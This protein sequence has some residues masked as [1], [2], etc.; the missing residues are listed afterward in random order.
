MMSYRGYRGVKTLSGALFI[1]RLKSAGFFPTVADAIA[2]IDALLFQGCVAPVTIS[3]GPGA[4]NTGKRSGE[5]RQVGETGSAR[6]AAGIVQSGPGCGE[7]ERSTPDGKE[8]MGR[9]YARAG[10]IIL[11]SA[12][13]AA[14][15]FVIGFVALVAA[16]IV[17]P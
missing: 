13:A 14:V 16:G 8:A 4:D 11:D 5:T 1:P 9:K 15:L 6:R 12:L 7:A 3:A 17:H 2:A 10:R